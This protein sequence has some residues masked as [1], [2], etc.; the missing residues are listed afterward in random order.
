VTCLSQ[1]RRLITLGVENTVTGSNGLEFQAPGNPVAIVT[2]LLHSSLP[3]RLEGEA[4]IIIYSSTRDHIWG[5]EFA[6]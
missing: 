6:W 2:R 5:E 4:R 3:R 1:P